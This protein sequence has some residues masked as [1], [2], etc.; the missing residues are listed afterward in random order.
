MFLAESV[1]FGE[2]SL[3]GDDDAEKSLVFL[4]DTREKQNSPSLSLDRLNEE[5][6]NVFSI[7]LQR[8]LQIFRM[9]E[10]NSPHL[11]LVKKGGTDPLQV[12]SKTSSALWVGTHT[13]YHP[14]SARHN[15]FK[16]LIDSPD[17]TEGPA[18]EIPFDAKNERLAFGNALALVR[19]LASE[20]QGRFDGFGT[21]IHR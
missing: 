14:R 13:V 4:V 21:S 16:R 8:T 20:L 2:V 10:A 12:R 6:R 15:E 1:N 5:R 17:D 19:P 7:Q 3:V 18:V 11:S 9:A